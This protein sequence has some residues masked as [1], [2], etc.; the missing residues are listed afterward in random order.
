MKK[1]GFL[2]LAVSSLLFVSCGNDIITA[3]EPENEFVISEVTES[4]E[5]TVTGTGRLKWHGNTEFVAVVDVTAE[6]DIIRK[7]NVRNGSFIETDAFA[8]WD[9]ERENYLSEYEGISFS[10]IDSLTAEPPADVNNHYDAG[11]MSG[12]ID[13]VSGATASSTVI[14]MAVKDAV[15]K[16]EGRA[17]LVSSWAGSCKVSNAM[18]DVVSGHLINFYDDSTCTIYYGIKAGMNGS[19]CGVYT[20]TYD[21]NKVSYSYVKADQGDVTEDSF[22]IDL[23]ADSFKAKVFCMANYPNSAEGGIDYVRINPVEPDESS[24]YIYIGSNTRDGRVSGALLGM[25]DGKAFWNEITDGTEFSGEGRYDII[26][27][28]VTDIDTP[29]VLKLDFPKLFKNNEFTDSVKFE[30]INFNDTSY[31]TLNTYS[32]EEK[33]PSLNMVAVMNQDY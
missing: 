25:S 14:A 29:D 27:S 7:I 28:D 5:R 17:E 8:R 1:I 15:K 30:E 10:Q 23:N 3:P 21:E 13:A 4:A 31:I 33:F 6:N 11:R 12:D 22:D 24:E 18:G 2:A 32:D 16:L 26:L 19:H 20:G 9:E